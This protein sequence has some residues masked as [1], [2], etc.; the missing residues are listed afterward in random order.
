VGSDLGIAAFFAF[1][2]IL[3]PVRLRLDRKW[4]MRRGLADPPWTGRRARSVWSIVPALDPG[5]VI[6]LA[7]RTLQEMDAR[8][9]SVPYEGVVVGWT[10]SM[11]FNIPRFEAYELAV[12]VGQL[13]VDGLYCLCCA[14]P[15]KMWSWVVNEI[16]GFWGAN[17]AFEQAIDLSQRLMQAAAVDPP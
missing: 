6:S 11:W 17:R 7:G 2:A 15:R 10:P 1:V 9:V 16:G 8:D 4:R 12:V 13:R 14:R 5:I 3:I